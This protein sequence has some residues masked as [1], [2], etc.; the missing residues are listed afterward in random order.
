[1]LCRGGGE[2]RPDM[3][4]ALLVGLRKASEFLWG[5]VSIVDWEELCATNILQLFH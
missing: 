3:S 5:S 4:N 1:V 2:E